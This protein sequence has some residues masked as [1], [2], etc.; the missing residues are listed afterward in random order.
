M[1][2]ETFEPPREEFRTLSELLEIKQRK[3]KA[4]AY[5]QHVRYL[6]S[7]MVGNPVSEFVKITI[8]IQGLSDGPVRDHLLRGELETYSKAIYA[9]EQEDSSVRQAHTTLTH[10]VHKDDRGQRSRSNGPLSSREREISTCER[11]AI[12]EISIDVIN[13]DTTHMNAGSPAQE[14]A[15]LSAVTVHQSEELEE[16]GP[17]L[18][19]S[20]NSEADHKNGRGQ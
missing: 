17:M 1:L 3:R 2:S 19:Q 11:Q 14:S 8:F 7:C 16:E 4:N 15:V 6:A 13:W 20:R 5:A 9:A 18:L 12:A 10:I